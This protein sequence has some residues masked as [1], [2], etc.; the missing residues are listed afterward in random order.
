MMR[1]TATW[2]PNAAEAERGRGSEVGRRGGRQLIASEEGEESPECHGVEHV[3][4]LEGATLFLYA[5]FEC[6]QQI[7]RESRCL[8]DC[9]QS[10]QARD[11]AV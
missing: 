11:E 4:L 6:P 5:G 3:A 2:W 1:R 7:L 8:N 9:R 10:S